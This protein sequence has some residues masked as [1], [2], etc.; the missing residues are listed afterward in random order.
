M[1][2]FFIFFVFTTADRRGLKLLGLRGIDNGAKKRGGLFKRT[3]PLRSIGINTPMIETPGHFGM[4]KQLGNDDIYARGQKLAEFQSSMFNDVMMADDSSLLGP[5]SAATMLASNADNADKDPVSRIEKVTSTLIDWAET[6]VPN[7]IR[8]EKLYQF[9]T[10]LR[11]QFIGNLRT[12]R[13]HPE[14]DDK[15]KQRSNLEL[16][17]ENRTLLERLV[18]NHL[19]AETRSRYQLEK[20]NPLELLGS[21]FEHVIVI[22]VIKLQSDTAFSEPRFSLTPIEL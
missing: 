15:I 2:L 21:F 18:P 22:S 14:G 10:K 13:A 5:R 12:C 6:Y 11:Q 20:E 19:A 4:F 9:A 1:K 3:S 8:K 7:Y 16:L 17:Q